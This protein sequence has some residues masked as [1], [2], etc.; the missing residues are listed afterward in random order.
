V[1]ALLATTRHGR[2][3]RVCVCVGARACACVKYFLVATTYQPSHARPRGPSELGRQP[4]QHGHAALK[5][6][7]GERGTPRRSLSGAGYEAESLGTSKIAAV[8]AM[9]RLRS[10]HTLFP[11]RLLRIRSC[12]LSRQVSS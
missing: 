9:A 2:S 10:S 1:V 4:G 8:M 5:I 7:T 6:E 3:L 12:I 11:S